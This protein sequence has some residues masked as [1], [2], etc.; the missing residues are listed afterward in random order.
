MSS[1]FVRISLNTQINMLLSIALL[2]F[3]IIF[4]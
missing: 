1:I 3:D 2:V 4:E